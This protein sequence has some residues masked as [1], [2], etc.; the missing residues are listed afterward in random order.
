MNSCQQ[1]K[2][3]LIW[4]DEFDG[5]GTPDTSKWTFDIGNWGWGNNELQ[6]YTDRP[7]NSYLS[8]GNLHIV[9]QREEYTASGQT[10]YYTSARMRTANK[11]DWVYGSSTQLFLHSLLSIFWTK[12]FF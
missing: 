11:G 9:A 8:E 2:R 7:E 3:S 4:S 12:A 10:R 5:E 1:E 6:Y